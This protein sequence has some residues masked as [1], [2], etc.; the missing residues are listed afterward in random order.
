MCQHLDAD[1]SRLPFGNRFAGAGELLTFQM[2]A[3][4][5][6][7]PADTRVRAHA[8]SRARTAQWALRAL[9][10]GS[11]GALLILGVGS[12]L[13]AAVFTPA[14][15]A[16]GSHWSMLGVSPAPCPG[17]VMCGMSRAFAAAFHGDMA[18]A[19]DLNPLVIVMLPAM[20]IA[21]A[22]TAWAIVHFIRRPILLG[23]VSR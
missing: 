10:F 20:L 5:H 4:M 21:T 1:R 7:R 8:P 17:C 19:Y 16:L 6:Q 15:I 12:V 2:D 22:A 11:L 9:V 13:I 23:E 18:L 14:E 3:V